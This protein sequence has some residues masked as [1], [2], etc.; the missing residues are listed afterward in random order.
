MSASKTRPSRRLFVKM[1][2]VA[3]A[4]AGTVG[5][6]GC[7]EDVEPGGGADSGVPPVDPKQIFPQGMASGDPTPSTV[8]LWT[9]LA[10]AEASAPVTYDVA[11]D[12]AFAN[13][14]ASGEVMA[15]V[16][17]D[18]TV[19]IKLTGLEPATVYYY[20]FRAA[21]ATTEAARTKT[22]PLPD[23]D[24]PVRFA[25]ASC[26][27]FNGRYYHSWKVFAEQEPVDFVVFL[28]D[29]IYETG[30][31][32]RFQEAGG[33]RVELPDGLD[34]GDG[35]G[36][37][38]LT[39]ADYRSLY[40]QYRSDPLLQAAHALAPF[41]AIWDDHEFADDC[42]QDHSTHFNGAQADSGDEGDPERRLAANRAW[43]E[44]MPVDLERTEMAWPND[45]K[46]YRKFR[47]GRH[48]ELV[49]TDLRS[50]R[51][52]HVIP[53]APEDASVGKFNP[54]SAVGSRNFLLKSGFDPKEAAA[55]PTM[56]GDP[57][58]QWLI[59]SITGSD[60][61]WKVWGNEVQLSQ[62]LIDLSSFEMVPE[63]YQEVFYFS[64]DQWDGYRTE[65]A[66]VLA[67]LEG[68]SGMVAICGDIHAAFATNIYRDF[69]NPGDLI[70]PEFTV[71][72]I[73]SRSVQ[74]ITQSTIDNDALLSALGLSALVPRFDELV[75][76]ASPHYAFARGRAYGLAIAEV[77]A[78]EFK[79]TFLL[80]DGVTNEEFDGQVEKVI[81]RY[82]LNGA[83]V[84][85]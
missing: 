64:V 30:N 59:D 32:P 49:L 43:F 83:L 76:A 61:T 23:A 78:E 79:T 28:G 11:T 53:E 77:T 8:I 52:D 82:P 56:L 70:L 54:N 3:T 1:V 45:I 4:A 5:L 73:S 33:R 68:T 44:Y 66:E 36:K 27:D 29:Y 2:V 39:L 47:F 34:L 31:D 65:R 85:S 35:N 72:G 15:E 6:Y 38:A 40:K 22:A 63:A 12:E 55:A 51:D 13:V 21:G 74:E 20:R 10:T 81:V 62:M 60:A 75:T 9:R 84:V 46:I 41:V 14:V 18:H 26:Q 67:A 69:D 17:A 25:F 80:V 50:Y 37:A 57:Q 19:R 42:W 48:M 24:V 16:D 7:G 71:P 58:K